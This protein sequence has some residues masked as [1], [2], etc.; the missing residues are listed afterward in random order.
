MAR[1]VR[2]LAVDDRPVGHRH[3]VQGEQHRAISG[4]ASWIART[5]DGRAIVE[6]RRRNYFSLLSR[7]HDVAAPVAQELQPGVCPLF[8]PLWCR[9]KRATQA[10]LADAGV[11]T[12]D[13]WSEGSPL[14]RRNEFLEVEA[15]RAHVLE[16]PIH[17]DLTS[18][19]MEALARVVRGALRAQAQ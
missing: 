4:L 7:L 1:T 2:P 8:Y 15:L 19:D 11:E 3:F 6:Q 10:L 14:V 13:F 16:L 12:I 9:N 5:L 18:E 17:Q